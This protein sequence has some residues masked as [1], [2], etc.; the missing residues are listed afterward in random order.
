[1]FVYNF[2]FLILAVYVFYSTAYLLL[3]SV[4]FFLRLR[5]KQI[6]PQKHLKFLILIPA[7]NEEKVIGRLLTSLHQ[8][9]YPE[10]LYDVS[11]VCDNCTDKTEEIVRERRFTALVREEK[12]LKGKGH[13]IDWALQKI[14]LMQY[15]AVLM[16]D[17]DTVVDSNVLNNLAVELEDPC[18]KVIQCYNGVLNPNQ[19][20]LTRLMNLARAL[21][22]INM[23]GKSSVGL[24]VHLVG[25][26][27]CFRPEILRQYP[28]CAY[29]ISEDLE[30]SCMLAVAGVRVSYSFHS[31][32]LLL[33]EGSF[34]DSATQ[35]Q[36]WS[37]GKVPLAL[38]F[39]PKIFWCGVKNFNFIQAETVNTLIVPNPSLLTNIAALC[40]IVL[41]IFTPWHVSI[42]LIGI[43][44]LFLG[45]VFLSALFFVR[46]FKEYLTGLAIAP[47]YLIWKGVIDIR[48]VFGKNRDHWIKTKRH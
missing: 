41:L 3:F 2:L 20:P 42:I 18:V 39:V 26:G 25:N 47:F 17:A 30:Y 46:N 10:K 16:T 14:E 35:R 19:T 22:I 27:M 44:L 24:S 6:I 4:I 45:M 40:C 37:S 7:H 32:I 29:S 28:W 48:A 38:R 8:L 31:R 36:R 12:L 13:A 9:E 5:K 23:A 34:S 33:E 43:S 11:V 21:E 1:M 15:D